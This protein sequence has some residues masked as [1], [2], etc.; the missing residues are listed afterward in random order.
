MIRLN[1]VTPERPFLEEECQSITLPGK[2]GEMQVL[3]G[4]IALL[5]ELKA[6]LMTYQRSDKE[7]VHCMVSEGFVEVDHDRVNVLCEQ[8]RRKSEVDK[9]YEETLAR[10]LLDQLKRHEEADAEQ[11]RLFAELARCTARLKLFE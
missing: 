7:M 10:E 6:G 2:E 8:A 5:A 4:H 3:P 11:K 9:D 1:I